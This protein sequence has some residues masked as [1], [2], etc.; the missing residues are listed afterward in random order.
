MVVA[1]T[2]VVRNGTDKPS[3]STIHGKAIKSKNQL[4]RLKQK[5]KKLTVCLY[6]ALLR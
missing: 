1:Q 2:D 4:R 3:L 5:Q 6:P